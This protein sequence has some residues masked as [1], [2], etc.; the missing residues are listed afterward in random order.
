MTELLELAQIP[1]DDEGRPKEPAQ[2]EVVKEENTRHKDTS[3][4]VD[5]PGRTLSPKRRADHNA[6]AVT[7]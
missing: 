5:G 1:E 2:V 3:T 6:S 7:D 4:A